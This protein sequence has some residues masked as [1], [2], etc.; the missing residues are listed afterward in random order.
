MSTNEN[1]DR[2]LYELETRMAHFER[3]ADDLSAVVADQA[4]TI[5]KLKRRVA[6]L[7]DRLLDLQEERLSSP[8][9]ERPPPH[10]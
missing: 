1:P 8:A 4:K 6:A 9:D 5:E 7:T 2:R 10:Y 3:T